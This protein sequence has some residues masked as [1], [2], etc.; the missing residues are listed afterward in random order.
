MPIGSGLR[1]IHQVWRADDGPIQHALFD[2]N[3]LPFMVCESMSQENGNDNLFGNEGEV[4]AT[5]I[6]TKRGQ[7]N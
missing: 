5:V 1:T 2:N 3:L 6:H 7:T 4:G